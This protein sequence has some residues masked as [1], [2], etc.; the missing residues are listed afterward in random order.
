MRVTA[1]ERITLRNNA[2]AAIMR[3]GR[4]DETGLRPHA[5]WHKHVHGVD[6]DPMQVLKMVE[7][8]QHPNTIDFSCR[9]TGKTTVKELYCLEVL[10]TTPYLE[11][12]IVAPRLQQSTN[13]LRYHLDAIDRSPALKAYLG[14]KN[15]RA[16][17]TD[18]GYRFA[19]R[20]GAT[21]YG[22]MS[23]V[24]GDSISIA[25]LEETDD[26][27][28]ERLFA[29]FLP[30]LGASRRLGAGEDLRPEPAIRITGV[31]K[32][33]DVLDSLVKSGRY[34]ELPVVDVY[35]GVKLGSLSESWVREM[36][37]QQSAGEW[38]RQFLCINTE[39]QNL[40][41]ERFIR[42]AMALGVQAGLQRAEPVPG[43]RYKKRGLV[44][45]GYDH[46]GHG[47][48]P[49]SSR[50]ALVVTEQMGS[51]V[52]VIYLRSW[53]AN[54]DERIIEVDL[55][56][57]WEYFNPDYAIGDAYGIGLLTVVNDRLFA[58]GL[59]QVN[60]MA[61]GGG[62]SSESTWRQWAFAPMRFEGTTKH[63]MATALRGF[64]HRQRAA[65]PA[66]DEDAACDVEW[67]TLVRQLANM[68]GTP[69]KGGSYDKYEMVEAKIGDDYFDALCA[70]AWAL[71]TRGL[72]DEPT[73]IVVRAQSLEDLAGGA[74]DVGALPMAEPPAL[75]SSVMRI[76]A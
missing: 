21:A 33:S 45:F 24:D 17:R 39:S 52:V 74:I 30:M 19:N 27:P 31:F 46:L 71:I 8:D 63:A 4:P 40:I 14:H 37:L 15:G 76:L 60:R 58:K 34:R 65:L 28:R 22:I 43:G 26:M 68:R 20:S 42:R 67:Q 66:F 56:G 50:S 32:G 47:E 55:V 53:P 48:K 25:S 6:L 10:A 35:L 59:T 29:N 62:T 54:T 44:T 72:A 61:I 2:E 7:M 64:F 38:M 73:R 70:A 18:S 23:Q 1:G 16:T 5:L 57:A 12:G 11:E 9:R 36:Q 51:F 41:W 13:N 69:I 75:P 3:F 49:E